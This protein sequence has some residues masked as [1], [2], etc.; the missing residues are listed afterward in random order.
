MN[1]VTAA[2]RT[3]GSLIVRAFDSI[4]DVVVRILSFIESWV[5]DAKHAQYGVA[6]T[7]ILLGV[8]GLGILLSN[9]GARSYLLGAG[10]AWTGQVVEPISALPDVWIFSSASQVVGNTTLLTI[11]FLVVIL[12]ALLVIV[13]WRGRVTLPLFLCLY[14]GLIEMENYTGDQGDNAFRILFF[15]LLFTDHSARFSLDARR[16][17]KPRVG[18]SRVLRVI[19]GEPFLPVWFT[20]ALH[21]LALVIITVQVCFIYAAGALFK[22]GGDPWKNGTAVYNAL[23]VERYAIWPEINELITAWAPMA[24]AA[25]VGSI[26]LQMSFPFMLLNR[27]TRIIALFGILSFHVAIGLFMGLPWFSM[28][29]IAADAIFIRDKTYVRFGEIVRDTWRSVR[30]GPSRPRGPK[31]GPAGGGPASTAAQPAAPA[32]APVSS[33]EHRPSPA[34]GAPEREPA[35]TASAAAGPAS[36]RD[37]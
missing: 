30:G 29:M 12:L 32:E 36:R 19:D 23:T 8:A 13:G 24:A 5:L 27:F 20:N 17:A 14:V 25:A 9:F 22:A 2:V 18:S 31:G 26:V 11:F 1:I 3:A 6:V 28:T 34:S 7:R 33:D 10:S 21:N 15:F 37:G 16:R 4:V 35:G